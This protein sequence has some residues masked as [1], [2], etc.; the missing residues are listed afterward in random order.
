MPTESSS[1]REDEFGRP[2]IEPA[3]VSMAMALVPLGLAGSAFLGAFLLWQSYGSL[4]R[5]SLA[6][7]ILL[8]G[9]AILWGGRTIILGTATVVDD[10]IRERGIVDGRRRIPFDDIVEIQVTLEQGQYG[11]VHQVLFIHRIDKDYTWIYHPNSR[12]V[13]RWMQ[14]VAAAMKANPSIV[15]HKRPDEDEF[16]SILTRGQG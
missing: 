1:A 16:E 15:F 4:L 7:L 10:T 5:S 14:I 9:M 11:A 3:P 2:V 13:G 6:V 12:T 8:V